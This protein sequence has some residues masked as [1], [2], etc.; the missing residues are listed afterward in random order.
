MHCL[1]ILMN[2]L[3]LCRPWRDLQWVQMAVRSSLMDSPADGCRPKIRFARFESIK[4]RSRQRMNKLPAELRFSP[5]QALTNFGAVR[6]SV[7]KT[8]VLIPA[9]PSRAVA[10]LIRLE[11]SAEIS[12]VQ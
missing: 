3:R 2:W 9:I 1:M 8:R 12:A 7:L 4:I 11:A 10:L 5:G 6:F